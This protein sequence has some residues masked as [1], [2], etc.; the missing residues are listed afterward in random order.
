MVIVYFFFGCEY[1]NEELLT[2]LFL[3]NGVIEGLGHLWFV[4]YIL[5]CYFLTPILNDFRNKISSYSMELQIC[6]C[7]MLVL[8]IHI[9]CD[10]F[11]PYFS[12]YNINCYVVRYCLSFLTNNVGDFKYIKHIL[13]VYTT[14]VCDEWSANIFKLYKSY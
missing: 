12:P 8:V 11:V 1:I 3:C 14:N 9:I 5:F 2:N 10:K 6:L 13:C 4:S 7:L